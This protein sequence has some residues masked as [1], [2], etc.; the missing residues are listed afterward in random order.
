MNIKDLTGN[1]YPHFKVIEQLPSKN[2][3]TMWRCLCE[4]GNLF[5]ANSHV[6]QSG[7]KQSCG[8]LRAKN[9][10]IART[11]NTQDLTG[12]RYGEL[13][14][15]HISPNS[16]GRGSKRLWT[17]KCH[18]C[19]KEKDFLQ[20]VL[21]SN[22]VKS[23]GCI[24]NKKA[25]ARIKTSMGIADGTNISKLKSNSMYASNTSGV[26]GVSYAK[27]TNKWHAYIQLKGVL[28]NLG[29][30]NTIEEATEA[31]KDAEQHLFGDF[32]DWYENEY[33]K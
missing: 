29:Y 2:N 3:R 8:C 27:K 19:G 14:V 16:K 31:R 23:C 26:K 11:K 18:A 15:L 10:A 17:C 30:Y 6:I 12:N 33:K 25:S 9:N 5:E 13:E 24:K 4:C 22:T 20:Y 21:T 28:Y 1:E 7:T 32:L